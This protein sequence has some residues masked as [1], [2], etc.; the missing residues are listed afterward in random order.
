MS[1]CDDAHKWCL[2]LALGVLVV[3]SMVEFPLMYTFFLMPAG[4][5][6]GALDER[7]TP[8]PKTMPLS[9]GRPAFAAFTAAMAGFL[10]FTVTEYLVVEESVRRVRLWS[11]G[12]VQP[13]KSPAPPNVRMIDGPRE[14][15]RMWLNEAR[16]GMTE[17]ELDWLRTV[18]SR[19]PSPS[20]LMRYA[21]AAG[22]NGREADAQYTL[23]LLCHV[24]IQRHC[25]EGR[26]AWSIHAEKH[27]K[28]LAIPFPPTP[29]RRTA[30]AV[31]KDAATY[32]YAPKADGSP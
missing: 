30:V 27:P 25:N 22:L 6:I 24:S 28:L 1:Q 31:R 13:G 5:L 2:L 29:H 8:M 23:R 32:G 3:H 7:T 11:A 15:V 18:V 26:T 17:A 19:T 10:Y 4:L 14:Y 21:L 16:P 12:Y 20:A 9:V